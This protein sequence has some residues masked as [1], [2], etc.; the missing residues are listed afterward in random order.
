MI[1]GEIRSEVHSALGGIVASAC[2]GDLHIWG[3]WCA[4]AG[5]VHSN[6]AR[7]ERRLTADDN[8]IAEYASDIVCG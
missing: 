8:L 7:L 4:A 5:C 3:T 2:A 1:C 6:D